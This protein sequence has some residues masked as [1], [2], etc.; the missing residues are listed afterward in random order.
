MTDEAAVRLQKL[1]KLREA[2]TD[3]YPARV[4]RS[5]A[6]REVLA[7]FD[8]LTKA[9]TEVAV[10]GR[11]RTV[12][13][14][15]GLTFLHLEDGSGRMQAALKRDQIGTDSYRRFAETVDI[16]DFLAVS[17][18]LFVTKIGERT[19]EVR[20]FEVVSK[21]LLPLPEKWH[22]L[23]DQETRYRQRYLDLIANEEVRAVFRTRA[24]VISAI[25]RFL[26]GQGFL[27]VETPILQA[28]PGGAN[29][30]PFVTHHNALDLDLF[31][32]VAPELYLKRCIVGG[33]ERVY[34]IGR[35]FRNEGVDHLHYPEFSALE[36]Y[37][38]Y[39]DYE[40]LM[41]MTERLLAE[42]VRAAGQDP[43]AVPYEGET[44]DFSGP[45]ARRSFRA[46]VRE[47]AGIDIEEY[48]DRD[49]LAKKA[50]KLGVQVLE[51]DGYGAILDGIFK[52]H[53]RPKIVQPTF[54][55][56]YPLALSPLAKKRPD[57]PRYVERFQLLV[58]R[59]SELVNAFS[60]LNDPQDQEERFRAQE[61]ARAAGDEEAQRLD[62]DFVTALKHGMPPTAGL[63]LGI[64]RLVMLLTGTHAIK[65][66]ILFPTLRPTGEGSKGAGE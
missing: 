4:K 10:V 16:G 62:E 8:A 24:A 35:N 3:P 54:V 48:P 64:E 56:D 13:E 12:R 52:K 58:A 55:T 17:G 26:D 34:E 27:E 59:G 30:R 9:R 7:D 2:G 43:A 32:R 57:D 46:A 33:F 45:Y 60:E 1:Q 65:E 25:R 42:T 11:V 40:E 38:A 61:E 29:A 41:T 6:I 47:H 18:P 23:S 39:A 51:S 14:H 15:G 37:M 50:E 44:L 63:G 31:L 53:V 36:F 28:I 19:V 21:A 49:S 22:G 20:G 5:H 66:V